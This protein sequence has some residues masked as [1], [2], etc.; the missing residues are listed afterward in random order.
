MRSSL[1]RFYKKGL[2][3]Q[4]L[5]ITEYIEGCFLI[6]CPFFSIVVNILCS[7]AFSIK[8]G[9][10]SWDVL[11]QNRKPE[12]KSQKIE[13]Q[14]GRPL[15]PKTFYFKDFFPQDFFNAKI[16]DFISENFIHRT[17]FG[18]YLQIYNGALKSFL[19]IVDFPLRFLC[20]SITCFKKL[21]RII[22]M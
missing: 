15:F 6:N 21:R 4:L 1:R 8:L 9:N 19:Q 16:Q 12:K 20:K 13:S 5:H 18:G 7:H 10:F 2:F 17:F 11:V 14:S 22:I 3:S